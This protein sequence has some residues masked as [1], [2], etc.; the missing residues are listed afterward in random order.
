MK[1]ILV[2]GFSFNSVLVSSATHLGRQ[3]SLRGLAGRKVSV[4]R[5]TR[6][7]DVQKSLFVLMA[8]PLPGRKR[9]IPSKRNGVAVLC[10]N[11]FNFGKR[12]P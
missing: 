3:G 9:I 4:R 1:T 11:G 2:S 7:P 12:K 6:S 10:E 8:F 5:K